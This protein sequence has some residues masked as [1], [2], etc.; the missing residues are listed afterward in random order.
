ML[1]RRRKDMKQTLSELKSVGK[2]SRERRKILNR[3]ERLEGCLVDSR[4]MRLLLLP[5]MRDQQG[6]V[7]KR[8]VQR[9]QSNRRGKTKISMH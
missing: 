9:N 7:V 2:E 3:L 6:P 4:R 1:R 5:L 8:L